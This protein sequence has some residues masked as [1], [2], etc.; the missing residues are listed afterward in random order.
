[1]S[2]KRTIHKI[3]ATYEI[4]PQ[5]ALWEVHGKTIMYHRY[6]ELAGARAGVTFDMPVIVESNSEKKIAN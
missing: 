5:D 4:A 1:M 6:V 3:L 2:D